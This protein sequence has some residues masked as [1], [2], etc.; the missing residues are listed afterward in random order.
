MFSLFRYCVLTQD[1]SDLGNKL[2]LTGECSSYVWGDEVCGTGTAASSGYQYEYD[3]LIGQTSLYGS[4]ENA[5]AVF[6]ANP[7]IF[8]FTVSGC[9]SLSHGATCQLNNALGMP[10]I[11]AEALKSTGTVRV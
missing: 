3:F 4:A 2:D 6:Q 10:P 7:Q 11:A 5:M 9:S 8:P 1:A